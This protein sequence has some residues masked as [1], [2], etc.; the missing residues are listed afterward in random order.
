M[1]CESTLPGA[2]SSEI[3]SIHSETTSPISANSSS[4]KQ[5]LSSSCFSASNNHDSNSNLLNREFLSSKQQEMLNMFVSITSCTI[6]QS[7][8][9]LTASNWQYQVFILLFALLKISIKENEK[10]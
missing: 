1:D 4:I 8:L 5:T 2:T 10:F 7:F 6:E 3:L 9:F